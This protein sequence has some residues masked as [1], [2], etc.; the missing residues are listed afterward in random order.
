MDDAFCGGGDTNIGLSSSAVQIQASAVSMI[1]A[2]IF[3]GDPRYIKGLSYDVGTCAAQGVSRSTIL[4]HWKIILTMTSSLQDHQD[5]SAHPRER[6]SHTVTPRI[7]TA[8]PVTM[9]TLINSMVTSM[10]NKLLLLLRARSH[11]RARF[12]WLDQSIYDSLILFLDIGW[13]KKIFCTYNDYS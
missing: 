4:L 1:K 10:V 9:P 13:R 7:H 6:S 2:A 5:F 3:M 11:K 8:A 12:Y